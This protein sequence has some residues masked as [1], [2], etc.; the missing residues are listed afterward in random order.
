LNVPNF[1]AKHGLRSAAMA[2]AGMIIGICEFVGLDILH[3]EGITGG[4]DSDLN[5]KVR[6]VINA[7]PNYDFIFLHFKGADEAAHDFNAQ[8]KVEYIEKI[9]EAIKLLLEN[10]DINE[11]FLIF[12]ADHSTPIEVGDH[13]ADP[14]PI[15]IVGPNVRVD[16]VSTFDEFECPKGGLIQIR[17][18]HLI[19]II[20]D[21]MNKSEK[22]GA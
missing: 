2:A 11:N 19:P 5:S 12:T 10:Y 1:S 14:V 21:L 22:F 16:D 17:G 18:K 20:L 15:M 7:L 3:A 8:E 4:V 6:S 9:D 13:S